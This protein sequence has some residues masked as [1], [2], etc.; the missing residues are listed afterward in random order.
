MKRYFKMIRFS[1][2]IPNNRDLFKTH[3]H[4]SKSDYKEFLNFGKAPS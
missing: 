1:M 3:I 4:S 2:N